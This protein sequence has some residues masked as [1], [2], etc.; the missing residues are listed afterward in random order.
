MEGITLGQIASAIAL[1]G[2]LISGATIIV[3]SLKNWLE[4]TLT[5]KFNAIDLRL[6][7]LSSRLD[8]VSME[9]CKNFL[10]SA[11]VDIESGRE[12]DSVELQRFWELF[13]FYTEISHQT[14][15]L[16]NVCDIRNISNYHTFCSQQS[17]ANYL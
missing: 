17:G 3:R 1:L 11:I 7:E 9:E 5:E 8:D 15:Q 4:S 13:D 10:V 12:I 2:G 16:A 6:D 14:N